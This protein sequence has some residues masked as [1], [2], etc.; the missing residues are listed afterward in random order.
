MPLFV[1]QKP[2]KV[3]PCATQV[4]EES[5]PFLLYDIFSGEELA[6]AQKIQRRRLQMLVHSRMYYLMDHNILD[7]SIFNNLAQELA[8]L[9]DAYPQIAKRVCFAEAFE[10]WDGST[11]FHLPLEHPWVVQRTNKLLKLQGTRGVQIEYTQVQQGAG[12]ASSKEDGRKS[13]SKQRSNT[14]PKG[15]RL[16]G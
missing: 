2:A 13:N 7:D 9:Q 15:R 8:E 3:E 14:V 10:D 1:T 16:F 4:Q 11:G 6:I 5:N 12:E